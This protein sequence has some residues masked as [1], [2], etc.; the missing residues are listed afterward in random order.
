M[1]APQHVA[2]P[3][4]QARKRRPVGEAF[5]ARAASLR[6]ELILSGGWTADELD[7]DRYKRAHRWREDD[8][9]LAHYRLRILDLAQR[10]SGRLVS[11]LLGITR[12]A[13][14]HWKRK[15]TQMD[16]VVL[17]FLSDRARGEGPL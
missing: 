2:T 9:G 3:R 11:R 10:F 1:L 15:Q 17:S 7:Y 16:A 13:L 6:A 5:E 12:Q 14:Q 8:V 4:S